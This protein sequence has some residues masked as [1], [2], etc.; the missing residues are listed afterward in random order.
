MVKTFSNT[1]QPL[2]WRYPIVDRNGCATLEFQRAWAQQQRA[3]ASIPDLTNADAVSV[4][5]DTLSNQYGS[6][7]YRSFDK[8][9]G[10]PP[11]KDTQ[12]LTIKKGAPTYADAAPVVPALDEGKI[13]VGD[14]SNTAAQVNMSGD[15][16]IADSGAVTVVGVHA[17]DGS[18]ATPSVSWESDNGFFWDSTLGGIGISFSGAQ[19]AVIYKNAQGNAVFGVGDETV[20]SA[21]GTNA[22]FCAVATG[23]DQVQFK[24]YGESTVQPS[25]CRYS[26]NAGGAFFVFGKGRGSLSSPANAQLN[27]IL[28]EVD[29]RAQTGGSTLASLTTSSAIRSTLIETGTVG[30]SAVGGRVSVLTCPIGSGTLSEVIRAQAAQ[31]N[32]LGPVKIG[33]ISATPDASALLDLQSTTQGF[34]PPRMTTTQR[35][36]I[37]SPADGLVVYDSTVGAFYFRQSSAWV[38]LADVQ[39]LL[40]LIGNTQGDVLYRGASSWAALAPGTSGQFLKTQGAGANPVWDTPS[41]GGGSGYDPGTVPS[42]VQIAHSTSAVNGVVMGSAPTSGNLLVALCFNSAS[43]VIGSGWTKY[44]EN[45][46]GTDWGTVAYKVAGASESTTQSPMS[47]T[48]TSAGCVIWEISGYSFGLVSANSQTEQSGAASQPVL[49]G[50]SKDCLGL[51]AVAI[52]TGGGTI[53]RGLNVGTQDVL[54]NTGNRHLLGGHTDLSKTPMVGLTAILSASASSKS[55]TC[56]VN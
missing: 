45:T 5:V 38:K 46:T 9:L 55:C 42:V 50:N 54:D 12:V 43:N 53:S 48:S 56:L 18:A 37:S 26:G 22:Q 23:S 13:F 20:L 29:F 17:A 27:D 24:L 35:N 21:I 10:L 31:Q 41:G 39:A 44:F 8:W 19:E 4:V 1:L 34:L 28:G 14:A 30:S 40:D 6:I 36:A 25:L 33:S 32:I 52:V 16:T 49:L 2:N 7:I 47:T 51:S 11:G 15:A 3:N